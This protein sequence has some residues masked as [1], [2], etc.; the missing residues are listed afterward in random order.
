MLFIV[1]LRT[2]LSSGHSVKLPVIVIFLLIQ[3]LL[4]S[5]H[6]AIKVAEPDLTELTVEWSDPREISVCSRY[7]RLNSMIRDGMISASAARSELAERLAAVRKDYYGRDGGNYHSGEWVF[8][9]A[10]YNIHAIGNGR[11]H[12]Y[13]PAGYDFFS[14][15]RHGGHPA[16]DI[17]I[18]DRNR[19]GRDERTGKKVT[20]L[21]MT[22][23]I[24]V[25][26]A[27]DWQ[28]GSK[29]RGGRYIWVYDPGSEL[30]VYYAHNE[31]LLVG[32]GDLVRPGTPIATVG[33]SGFNA[34][35][36]RS[37]T[38]LHL[39]ALRANGEAVRP[40][41]IYRQLKMSKVITTK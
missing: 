30:L 15:N 41:D 11:R 7:N 36:K 5:L 23:G 27:S 40:V 4:S 20:V 16:Y 35:K 26:M 33:R 1:A 29:L 18:R 24:V 32:L 13:I 3:P 10:G 39:S 19:E 28:T 22:G 21:S 9:L 6:A 17:F 38:H 25:A 12:G 2:F 14:G 31:E 34:A 8:P 37:P